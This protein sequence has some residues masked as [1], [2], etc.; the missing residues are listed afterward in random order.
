[1]TD[2]L[3]LFLPERIGTKLLDE[4]REPLYSLIQ[5]YERQMKDQAYIEQQVAENIELMGYWDRDLVLLCID[6]DLHFMKLTLE[7]GIVQMS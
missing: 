4:E 6:H 3:N 7:S 2:I 1:M 5:E